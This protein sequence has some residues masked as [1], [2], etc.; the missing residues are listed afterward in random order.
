MRPGSGNRTAAPVRAGRRRS[1]N[2]RVYTLRRDRNP[3]RARRRQRRRRVVAQR[4]VRRPRQDSDV[5]LLELAAGRRRRRH[6]RGGREA[7]GVRRRDRQA[8]LDRRRRGPQLQLAAAGHDRRSR[9]GGVH[10][11]ARHDQRRAGHR[12]SALG[13]PV[14]G[15]RDRSAGDDGGRRHPGQHHLH[16]RGRRHAPPRDRAQRPADGRR[17]SAGRQPG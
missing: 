10:E 14:V 5:G 13:V 12:E 11:R 9:A 7:R 2:G 6:R 3:E 8:A 15:R 16:E 1:S 4:G 17:R